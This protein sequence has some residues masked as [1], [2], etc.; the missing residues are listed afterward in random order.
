MN[1]RQNFH[2]AL[3]IIG[4]LFLAAGC[5]GNYTVE[6]DRRYAFIGFFLVLFLYVFSMAI[7]FY[8]WQKS[9]DTED[10]KVEDSIA[11]L[12]RYVTQM[13]RKQKPLIEKPKA[14]TLDQ[15][16]SNNLKT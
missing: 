16:R 13:E 10:D 6:S 12:E 11:E 14:F 3:E 8:R 2:R 5:L 15:I 7:N 9:Y 1:T 4:G